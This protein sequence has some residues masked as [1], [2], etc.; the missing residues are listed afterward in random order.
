M[1]TFFSEEYYNSINYTDYTSRIE[2]YKRTALDFYTHFSMTESTTVLDYGCAIGMLQ[3]GLEKVGVKDTIGFEISEWAIN[4]PIND[5][6]K[7]TMNP[8]VLSLNYDYAF[9]LDVFEHMFDSD[10]TSVLE[11]LQAKNLIVRIP[12]KLIDNDDFYLAVSRKDKSH[13]NC[14]TKGGWIDFIEKYNYKFIGILDLK[15]IYDAPGC[16]CGHFAK[17]TKNS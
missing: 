6:L 16:F 4:N 12:V 8:S 13:V 1:K 11:S 3:N 7:L 10:V 17:G 9:S 14:K 2:K 15:T 5:T